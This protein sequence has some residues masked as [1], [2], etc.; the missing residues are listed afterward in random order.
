MRGKRER[1]RRRL[2]VLLLTGIWALCGCAISR[3]IVDIEPP[4][5]PPLQNLERHLDYTDPDDGRPDYI[6]Q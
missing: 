1:L 3:R 4:D 2:V 6:V 5:Q